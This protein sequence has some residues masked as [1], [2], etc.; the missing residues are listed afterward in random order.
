MAETNLTTKARLKRE[1]ERLQLLSDKTIQGFLGFEKG[2]GKLRF[3]QIAISGMFS[4]L[5]GK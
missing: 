1:Y 4:A 3:A 2:I 5:I